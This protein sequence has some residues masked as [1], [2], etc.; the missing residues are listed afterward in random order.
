M[1][2]ICGE[3][4]F[5]GMKISQE[6]KAQLLKSIQFRGPDNSDSFEHN[7]IFLGHSRLSIIDTSSK[8]NQP[9]IDRELNL[10]I[11]FN[12]VIYNYKKLRKELL[13]KG[14]NFS[15]DGDTEVII[16]AYH[17]YGIKCLDYIDGVFSFCIYDLVKKKLFLARDRFGIKPLYY[18]L[19]NKRMIF[20]STM[21]SLI[22]ESKKIINKIALN[23]HFSLHSVVPAPHTIF[24]DIFKLEQGHYLEINRNGKAINK[25]YYSTK[26]IKINRDLDEN[27]YN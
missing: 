26:E 7:G 22:K 25:K 21:K 11:V 3:I 12:G 24:D 16:K 2:G 18:S 14:Y 20:S 13:D 4:R 8:S 9:M 17:F 10:A 1:C 5:D 15:S 27:E 6:H 23:Y 19:N